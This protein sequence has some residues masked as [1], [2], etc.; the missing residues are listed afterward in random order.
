MEQETNEFTPTAFDLETQ[1]K[2]LQILKTF[3]PYLNPARQKSFAV[4]V[5]FLELRN[6]MSIFEKP[7]ASMSICSSDDPA[8]RNVQLLNDLKKFCSP[9]EQESIDMLL[10]AFS[11]FSF[12]AAF[13]DS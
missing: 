5:K 2:N 4:M 10:G 12:S 8:E 9:S 3:I 13:S 11:T 1:S 6:V 7:P